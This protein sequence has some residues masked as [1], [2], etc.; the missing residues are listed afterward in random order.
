V[1]RRAPW[2]SFLYG[3]LGAQTTFWLWVLCLGTLWFTARGAVLSLANR[4]PEK[5]SVSEAAL[6]HDL[7]RWVILPG[8]RL[9]LGRQLLLK[10]DAHELEAIEILIDQG[11]PCAR[12]WRGARLV[13]DVDA[14]FGREKKERASAALSD[15]ALAGAAAAPQDARWDLETRLNEFRRPGT[16]FLPRAEGAILLLADEIAAAGSAT[17]VGNQASPTEDTAAHY[18]RLVDAWRDAIRSNVT[19]AA[20]RGLLDPAPGRVLERLLKDPGVQL[21]QNALRVERTPND[22]ELYVFCGAAFVFVF[23]AAGLYGVVSSPRGAPS[24]S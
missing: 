11:D 10:E 3:V 8:V 14:G 22:A 18:E 12:F 7:R 23:L 21:G 13:A 1:S 6:S 9:Q 15:V 4:S 5:R 20:P 17:Y 2:Y 16:S 24:S 19:V